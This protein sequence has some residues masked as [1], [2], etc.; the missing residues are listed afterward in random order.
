MNINVHKYLVIEN[1][2]DG[3]RNYS[4]YSNTDKRLMIINSNYYTNFTLTCN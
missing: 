2:S 1:D 4:N 3:N